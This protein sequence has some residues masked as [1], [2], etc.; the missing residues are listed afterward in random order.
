LLEVGGAEKTRGAEKTAHKYVKDL[1]PSSLPTV[2][3]T[4]EC[5][6]EFAMSSNFE[7]P[8]GD[9]ERVY[10]HWRKVCNKSRSNYQKVSPG[11]KQKILCRLKEFSVEE[12]CRA[13]DGVARD[14][15][16]GRSLQN[17]LTI[18]FRSQEQVEKFLELAVA[19]LYVDGHDP[20]CKHRMKRGL[21]PTQLRRCGC[22]SCQSLADHTE[23]K[24]REFAI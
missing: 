7:K 23:S 8:D 20:L 13:I 2:S 10:E 1:N 6:P 16:N 3:S 14:P 19:P 22:F 12:L 9:V 21:T 24:G 5:F 15:W 11:R 4:P 18:I 17:D